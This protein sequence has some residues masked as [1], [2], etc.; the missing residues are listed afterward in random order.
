MNLG[1]GTYNADLYWVFDLEFA[2]YPG[3]C[4][5]LNPLPAPSPAARAAEQSGTG[6]VPKK[7]TIEEVVYDERER[8][9][10]VEASYEAANLVSLCSIVDQ[11]ILGYGFQPMGTDTAASVASNYLK[12]RHPLI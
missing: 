1:D 12:P 5:R 9:F 10:L 6:N 7:L 4:L 3:L 2:P 8:L 11:L